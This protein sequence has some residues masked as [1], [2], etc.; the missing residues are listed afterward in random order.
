MLI[1]VMSDLL[2]L[3]KKILNEDNRTVYDDITNDPRSI[4]VMY[5][6]SFQS[7]FKSIK[8]TLI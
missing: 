5:E 8:A 6:L 3:T 2:D 4:E 7:P 1:V